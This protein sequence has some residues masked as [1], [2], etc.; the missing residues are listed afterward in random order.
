MFTFILSAVALSLADRF[1]MVR[2]KT[3]QRRHVNLDFKS[4]CGYE[5]SAMPSENSNQQ[6]L[7]RTCG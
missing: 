3:P 7:F 4:V 5:Y 2:H 6:L 1:I